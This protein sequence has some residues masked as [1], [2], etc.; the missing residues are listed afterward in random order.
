MI[1]FKRPLLILT[2]ITL[3]FGV[4]NHALQ[5]WVIL[6]GF[7]ILEHEQ[8][9]NELQRVIDAINREIEHIELLSGDWAMWD[10]TYDFVQEEDPQ[11]RQAYIDSNLVWESLERATGINL[12]FIYSNKNELLWGGVFDS[13]QGGLIDVQEFPKS[14]VPAYTNLLQHE[15]LMSTISGIVDSSAGPILIAS[16]PILTTRGDG[17]IAG[18]IL[19]GRFLSDALLEKMSAQTR[20]EF[21]A[22]SLGALSPRDALYEHVNHLHLGDIA[23]V[24]I[25][26]NIL[27]IDGLIAGIDGEP[28]LAVRAQIPRSI[29]QEGLHVAQLSSASVL[30]SFVLLCLFISFGVLYYT[31]GI[32]VANARI[33]GLVLSRTQELRIAKEQA[34]EASFSAAAA[35]ESKSAFLANMSHEIRTPMNAI[36][37]LS[38]LSLQN[39]LSSKQRNYIEKV[40]NSANFLLRII[41]DILD[42]SKV[43]AGKMHVEMVDFSLDEML[44]YLA[45]LESLK[46]KDKG[47]QFIFDVDP[48]TPV[49][50]TG[51]SLR[52]NQV[53]MNLL[54]N[55]IKFTQNGYVILSIRVLE[56][57]QDLVTIEFLVEDSGLGMSQS[58]SEQ[59]LEPFTQADAST[60]R[61]FGG[62]GL[63]LVISKQLSELMGGSL[64]LSSEEG[65]GTK[66]SVTL[67][68][69]VAPKAS[70]ADHEQKVMLFCQDQR[71]LQAVKN[72]LSTYKVEV[73][74]TNKLVT[75]LEIEPAD[76][77][78]IDDSFTIGE[79]IEFVQYQQD[80]L[81]QYYHTLKFVLLSESQ[82]LPESLVS[83]PIRNLKKPVYFANFLESLTSTEN[84][85]VGIRV[86]IG[87]LE[88][89]SSELYQKIGPQRIL[90]AEDNELNQEIIN[91]LLAD[92]GAEVFIA[93]DGKA[94][95]DL[96]E[97]KN[98][99]GE[100]VDAILMDIQMPVMNGLEASRQIRSQDKWQHI[101]IIALSASATSKDMKEG[102]AIGMNEYLSK[103][104]LPEA[105]FSA[106]ARCCTPKKGG[107][108]I[109]NKSSENHPEGVNINDIQ[110]DASQSVLD[111]AKTK[112][113][114]SAK[115][116]GL[117]ITAGLKTCNGKTA[118][119]EKMIRKFALKY[120][121]IDEELRDALGDGEIIQA[122]ALAHNLRGVSANIGA[123]QLS[124]IAG[125]I[126][127]Q[128]VESSV[129]ISTLPMALFS[130]RLQ[131][132]IASIELYYRELS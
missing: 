66:V 97:Q 70:V 35:N 116:V 108:T 71:T 86:N 51:D 21:T 63:G 9:E 29:M 27:E 130:E 113:K 69:S 99:M 39:E 126:E 56:R 42:F 22:H 117:D 128:L 85:K 67:P 18:S 80:R 57:N 24:E 106:L 96:L 62:T 33:K 6:P 48:D 58:V 120:K 2:F 104:I 68:M 34:E 89:L 105:L 78:L 131:Q 19:M 44:A 20:V 8:A 30:V 3:F 75:T 40:N 15:S 83:Y 16:R 54:S 91:D 59:V 43:E 122:K 49:F 76:V 129:D 45:M 28:L 132:V 11:Y 61:H 12:I 109:T 93:D 65:K 115:F 77:L 107:R 114:N 26:E 102:L 46:G 10:D 13:A 14:S 60:T 23:V 123:L 127:D 84:S 118:L 53:L 55:A 119:F 110:K 32:R 72:T 50:L 90:L 124:D 47:I 82:Q 64:K 1:S 36:I 112:Q 4:V 111:K 87:S 31:I 52:L 37:N 101:P 95:I 5:R 94:A 73:M 79:I 121:H 103:P 92:C 38:Y 25:N 88:K 81:G 125:E 100:G 41:N 7:T 98:L 17:P 74:S